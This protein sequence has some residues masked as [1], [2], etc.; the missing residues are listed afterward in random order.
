[1]KLSHAALKR[2]FGSLRAKIALLAVGS[3]LR[4]A[5]ELLERRIKERTAELAGSEA[6]FRALFESSQDGKLVVR[7]GVIVDVNRALLK[8]LH[9]DDPQMI[10][11]RHPAEFSPYAGEAKAE[12]NSL[13]DELLERTLQC[14]RASGEWVVERTDGTRFEAEVILSAIDF[15]DGRLVLASIRDVTDR[16]VADRNFALAHQQLQATTALQRAI[17][18]S[19]DYAIIATDTAGKITVFNH[20]AERLLGYESRDVVNYV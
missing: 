14:G 12:Q 20:G 17:L 3:A 10:L 7:D 6:R 9:A 4:T 16:N 15:H 2:F 11:G 1:M 18:E 5:N 13:T 19:A 8:L